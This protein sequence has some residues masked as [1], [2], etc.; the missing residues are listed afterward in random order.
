MAATH[1][2]VL[3]YDTV[4]ADVVYLL[5]CPNMMLSWVFRKNERNATN[6]IS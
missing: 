6:M 5:P 2:P 4:Y 1:V 3:H